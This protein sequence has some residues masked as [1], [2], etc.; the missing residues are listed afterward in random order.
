MVSNPAFFR[1]QQS[2]IQRLIDGNYSDSEE[3]EMKPEAATEKLTVASVEVGPV[4]STNVAREDENEINEMLPALDDFSS[5]DDEDYA[6]NWR[7]RG[8]PMM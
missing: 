3:E 6:S 4:V 1:Q 8:F 5:G 2:D 7:D